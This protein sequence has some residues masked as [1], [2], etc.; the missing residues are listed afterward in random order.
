M[1][2]GQ[3]CTAAEP[4]VD[5][6]LGVGGEPAAG[7]SESG[8]RRGSEGGGSCL[9]L[10]CARGGSGKWKCIELRLWSKPNTKGQRTL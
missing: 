4:L 10:F 6:V 8:E 7:I 2:F 1:R 9:E 3:R 5:D